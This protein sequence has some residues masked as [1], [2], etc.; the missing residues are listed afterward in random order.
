MKPSLIVVAATFLVACASNGWRSETVVHAWYATPPGS[1][2]FE[3]PYEPPGGDTVVELSDGSFF[4]IPHQNATDRLKPGTSVELY[5][6]TSKDGRTYHSL[7]LGAS[8]WEVSATS[9][10]APMDSRS[11][12]SA[13]P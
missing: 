1:D 2:P 12:Q 9:P 11:Q 7:R 4:T 6:V 3:S 10:P 8:T 5:S 13:S